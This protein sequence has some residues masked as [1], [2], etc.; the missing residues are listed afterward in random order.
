MSGWFGV[1]DFFVGIGLELLI[2]R[3]IGS[4]LELNGILRN[5]SNTFVPSKPNPM[6]SPHFDWLLKPGWFRCPKVECPT[7]WLPNCCD[8]HHWYA[9]LESFSSLTSKKI[10]SARA[11]RKSDFV[12]AI[13]CQEDVSYQSHDYQ[14]H[15]YDDRG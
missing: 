15:G 10:F 13:I 7:L 6:A 12:P 11:G 5:S 3:T 2:P 4:V 1:K 14:S 9:L 8:A